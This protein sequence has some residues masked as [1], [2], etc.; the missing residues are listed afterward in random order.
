[1]DNGAMIAYLGEIMLKV[2]LGVQVKDLNKIDILPR[3]RTD[4]VEISWK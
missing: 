2:G 3:Q 4:D 1:V